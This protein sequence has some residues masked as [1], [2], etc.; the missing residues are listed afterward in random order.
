VEDGR[1][2]AEEQG[3]AGT[4]QAVHGGALRQVWRGL[5]GYLRSFDLGILLM[6]LLLVLCV[7]GATIPQRTLLGAQEYE[8]W[9]LSWPMCASVLQALGITEVFDSPVFALVLGL[10][11][12]NLGACSV[13]RV[14]GLVAAR[15]RLVSRGWGSAV[16]H[17]S[18]VVLFLGGF[19]GRLTRFEGYV[20]MCEGGGFRDAHDA[21]QHRHEGP[22]F[23][24]GYSGFDVELLSL[25]APAGPLRP[26]GDRGSRLQIQDGADVVTG[27]TRTGEP[28]AVHGLLIHQSRNGG[29]SLTFAYRSAGGCVRRGNVHLPP[30]EPDGADRAVEF[31]VPGTDVRVVGRLSMPDGAPVLVGKV[32]S[33]GQQGFEVEIPCGKSVPVPGGALEF[34]RVGRWSGLIVSRDPGSD[35]VFGGM[36]AAL[37]GAVWMVLAPRR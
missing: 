17:A 15:A 33:N 12:C 10:L 4:A 5:A 6:T 2:T 3:E 21:Y 9:R 37:L 16:F 22:L 34:A 20:E 30:R 26:E 13:A 35:W 28:L 1:A 24:D 11:V 14:R 25:E 32:L 29:E 19:V 7:A 36:F 8:R 31:L 18:L 27:W 23:L